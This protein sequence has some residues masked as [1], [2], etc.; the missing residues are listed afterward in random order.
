MTRDIA[1]SV[2]GRLAYLAR[3]TNRP[4]Q[5]IT[6]HTSSRVGGTEPAFG[7][8]EPPSSPLVGRGADGTTA[9]DR[10]R[11]PF[12]TSNFSLQTSSVPAAGSGYRFPSVAPP[13]TPHL[14]IQIWISKSPL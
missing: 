8:A 13:S 7:L 10:R 5:D 4:L 9:R 1:A 3:E 6:L 12:H 2:R 11:S 14:A